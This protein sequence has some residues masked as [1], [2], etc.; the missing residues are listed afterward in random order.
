MALTQDDARRTAPRIGAPAQPAAPASWRQRRDVRRAQRALDDAD[1]Q[2]VLDALPLSAA[3]SD[4]DGIIRR[5][6]GS[7]R[8]TIAPVA[9]GLGLTP[10]DLVGLPASVL[11]GTDGY[12]GA[13]GPSDVPFTMVVDNGFDVIELTVDTI[14]RDGEQ[15]GTV[16]TWTS[17]RDR[18]R[19]EQV[20]ADVAADN[21]TV[22][23]VIRGLETA[24]T[25]VEAALAAIDAV[26]TGQGWDVGSYWEADAEAGA[27]RLVAGSGGGFPG[28]LHLSEGH[29]QQMGTGVVGRAWAAGTAVVVDDLAADPC[30]RS[31]AAAAAGLRTAVGV[32]I[33]VGGSVVGV[34]DLWC[35]SERELVQSRR[36][37]L[38]NIGQLLSHAV[39]RLLS[40][41]AAIDS[42][43]NTTAVAELLTALMS[44]TTTDE[45]GAVA[46]S[47]L[48][49]LF[50]WSYG[51]L[52][53]R[54]GGSGSDE[55]GFH[56][57]S[58]SAAPEFTA[59]TRAARY[60]EGTGLGGRAWSLR[61]AVAVEDLGA[62]AD[63]PR[64]EAALRHGVRG[65]VAV[66]V[67]VDGEVVAALDFLTDASGI[68]TG[69]RLDTL[70]TVGRLLSQT[71]GR[72]AVEDREREAARELQDGVDE[73]LAA[74][75]AAAGGDLTT[76][77]D[78]QG[79]ASL[80]VMSGGLA[81]FLTRLRRSLAE[82]S[83]VAYALG[84][85]GAELETV[86]GRMIEDASSTS[87]Q[88]ELLTLSASDVAANVEGVAGAAEQL[89]A[90]IA[91]IAISATT[92]ARVAGE[93]VAVASDANV[94]VLALD[95]SS[96]EIGKVIKTI[97]DIADQTNLLAL[98]ATIEAARAG[99][100]GKGFAVVAT[101]V[102]DLAK[103]TARATDEISRR[104]EA[105][106]DSTRSAIDAITQITAVIE[107]IDERQA[108]ISTA[109]EEQTAT[110]TAIAYN[111]SAA[112]AGAAAITDGIRTVGQAA[113]R[114]R[115]GALD[116]Q[117]AAQGLARMSKEMLRMLRQFRY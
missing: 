4:R 62:L 106:Q 80:E 111:V 27:L 23:R 25:A 59:A 49:S 97:T 92:A 68:V 38:A 33:V 64:G 26:R 57:D 51:A 14:S 115:S 63:C 89:K 21:D 31:G 5:L 104:I 114:T 110:T 95:E 78:V 6:N 72:I 9:A 101:E 44:A 73:L 20:L 34:L 79:S 45:A 117:A 56:L 41:Q 76:T 96:S 17:M 40:E 50:G 22:S 83:E 102:K 105:I 65:A 81:E 84:S 36:E 88:V 12:P 55:L 99:D 7:A 1:L 24:R 116:S 37:T 32:P 30:P 109:V 60:R 77:V 19:T 66:P 11:D 93:A 75:R 46:L 13:A 82:I 43:Q 18:L 70:R 47:T 87:D 16:A 35:A 2:S 69:A 108:A 98:N 48:R 58:G 15:L 54:E 29:A 52:W 71:F 100:A 67:L 91:E 10:D 86:S 85:A 94:S 112:A 113:D 90:S 103:E 28:F 74:V 53:L 8:A 61:S 3:V 39:T 42:A 107:R